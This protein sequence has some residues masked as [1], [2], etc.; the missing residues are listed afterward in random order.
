MVVV[1]VFV[2]I[3]GR[4]NSFFFISFL[5]S[6][7]PLMMI[8]KIRMIRVENL[9]SPTTTITTCIM[10]SFFQFFNLIC[11]IRVVNKNKSIKEMIACLRLV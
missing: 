5:T 3:E 8:A 2:V 7:G 6:R 11:I 1:V 9:L 4:P 10:L